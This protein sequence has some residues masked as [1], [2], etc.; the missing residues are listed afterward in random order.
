MMISAIRRAGRGMSGRAA[1]LLMGLV[2]PLA[3]GL[4]P[5]LAPDF[6]AE[7]GPNWVPNWAVD[8][9]P[10]WAADWT[11]NWTSNWTPDW[12]SNWTPDL[13]AALIGPAAA[14]DLARPLLMEGKT[15]TFQRILTKPGATLHAA[16]GAAAGQAY[17]PFQPLYVYARQGGWDQVGPWASAGPL[18]WMPED[19][20]VLWT[21]NIVAA[22]T[23][24]AG[25]KRQLIFDSL[26]KLQALMGSEDVM[27][28]ET[29]LLAQADTGQVDPRSGVLAVEPETFINTRDQLYQMPIL[30]FSLSFHPLNNLPD[31][32]META[33]IPLRPPAPDAGAAQPA[34]FDAGIVFVLDSTKSIGPSIERTRA[35]VARIVTEIGGTDLGRRVQFGVIGFRDDPSGDP[36]GIADRTRVLAP[37]ARRPYQ[38]P[39]L[40]A[41]QAAFDVARV[42]TPGVNEDSMAGVEDAIDSLDWAPGGKA[43]DAKYVILVTDAGPDDPDDPHARSRIGPAEIQREAQEEGIAVL[44]LHL[45]APASGAA[46]HDYAQS[47]T[48]RR[49]ILDGMRQKL[50]QYRKWLL[51]PA[52]WT[53]LYDGAPDGEMV[54]AMPFAVL[55]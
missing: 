55:P 1:A 54:Y 12:T 36:E 39:V 14:H 6:V 2:A 48:K 10:D 24:P 23:H 21:Q 35:A 53:A 29:D 11:S 5:D 32:L 7:R 43:F 26:D 19:S 38:G 40:A 22:F 45:K 41:I 31:L 42:S 49:Q 17:P 8:W 44:T 13:A 46:Q 20:V 16:P 25:R 51:D 15:A 37:L 4:A 3:A 52:V 27:T 34:P 33:S 50:V 18:G 30:A 47:A 28:E 9:R